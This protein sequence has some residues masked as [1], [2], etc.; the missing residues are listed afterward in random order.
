[1]SP[2]LPVYL[3]HQATTPVDPTVLEGMLPW[4]SE[5]FGNS[6]SHSH[7]YGWEAEEAVEL[8]RRRVADALGVAPREI[9]L[10]SGATESNNLAILGLARAWKSRGKHL[11]SC[12]T[13]HHAVLDPLRA[14]EHEGFEV[15]ILPVAPDGRVDPELVA[16][17]LR[18]DTILLSIMAANNEIGVLQPIEA[19]GRV[20]KERGIPFHCDAA[21][22]FGKIP[23]EPAPL[24]VDL[25]SLSAHKIYGPKGVGALWLRPKGPRIRIEP[26]LH[27]GG[28]EKG[29]RPGT[30]NV[31]AIVGLGLAAELSIREMP[32]EAPRLSRLRD[33]LRSRILES[34]GGVRENGNPTERL[35]GNLNLSFDGVP[36]E[37]L[38]MELRSLAVSSGSACASASPEPSHVLRALGLPD[39]L[40]HASLRFGLGR[41]T[42]LE[43]IDFAADEVI[44]AVRLLRSMAPGTEPGTPRSRPE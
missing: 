12:A 26:L 10:T 23:F 3:D 27:G 44:R 6:S 30:L 34:L 1:V 9:V 20:A 19:L 32:T 24:G 4:F 16:G 29:L 43:E 38:L 35:P 2:N 17:A 39:D 13:E 33:R 18:S 41:T 11:V 15:T 37:A 42:T 7:P 22:A 8:A 40:A 21:Q 36:G 28:Q 31:P 5:K 14:L 25:V